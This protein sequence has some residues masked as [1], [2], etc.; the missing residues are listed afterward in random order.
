MVCFFYL[1]LYNKNNR[2]IPILHLEKADNKMKKITLILVFLSCSLWGFSMTWSITA[3]GTSFV[4][5]PASV[6]IAVLDSLH[7][8]LASIHN[9]VE[10]SEATWVANDTTA[11]S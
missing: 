10:V 4:F 11:L 3:S 9:A 6:T 1:I 8:T 2:R 5:V 7:F